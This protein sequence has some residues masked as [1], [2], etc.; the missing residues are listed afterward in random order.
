M[1]FGELF[2]PLMGKARFAGPAMAIYHDPEFKEE[3]PDVEVAIPI[4]GALPAD[5]TAQARELPGGDM[6]CAV[7]QGSRCHTKKRLNSRL[8]KRSSPPEKAVTSFLP[9]ARLMKPLFSP[10]AKDA[11]QL[12]WE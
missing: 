5:T 6:A 2:G 12:N 7:Y 4:E 8:I 1:L 11:P 10:S 3:N 9:F